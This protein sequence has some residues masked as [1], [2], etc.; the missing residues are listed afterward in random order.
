VTLAEIIPPLLQGASLTVPLA[1]LSATV[2]FAVAALTGLALVSRWRALRIITAVYVE[3]FRG[4]SALVQVFYFFFVLP[5][6]GLHLSAV[7][8]GVLALG[9]NYGA[10]GSQIVRA[11]VQNV[12][13]GQREAAAALNMPGSLALRRIILPQALPAMLP[14]FGNQLIEILKT[15]SLLSVIGL[16]ELSFTGKQLLLLD[17]NAAPIIYATVLVIY[18]LLAFPL[19]RLVRWLEARTAS[20]S[21]GHR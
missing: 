5:L 2:A 3:V 17:T 11:A 21:P 7:A 12:D 14:P 16:I 13:P 8:A 10:Y 18:L 4:T 20:G 9:L 19:T 6:L 1:L 15:T